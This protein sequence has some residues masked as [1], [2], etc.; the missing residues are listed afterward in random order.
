M[1][2]MQILEEYRLQ[3]YNA[4]TPEEQAADDKKRAE[5]KKEREEKER[6]ARIPKPEL[7]PL[8]P[9]LWE[10]YAGHIKAGRCRSGHDFCGKI[11]HAV[12]KRPDSVGGDSFEKALCG[13]RPQGR[14]AG[15]SSTT[16]GNINCPK[17]LKKFKSIE[18]VNNKGDI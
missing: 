9:T 7:P 17:C 18:M 5:W 12:L 6:K 2:L 16:Y 10:S 11:I 13:T 1:K 8:D 4:M 3:E 15:W 14:S